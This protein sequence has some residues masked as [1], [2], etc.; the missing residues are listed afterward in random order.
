MKYLPCDQIARPSSHVSEALRFTKIKLGS[1]KGFLCALALSNVLNGAEQ[2]IGS[3]GCISLCIARQRTPTLGR[4]TVDCAHFSAGT[5]DSK[6]SLGSDS[7]K[8]VL[9]NSLIKRLAIFG[10]D[11]RAYGRQ[12]H[13]AFLQASA[14]NA[15]GF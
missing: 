9:I 2:F 12:V 5:H 10:V 8:K 1:L 7:S 3:S 15:V 11:H 6:F 14:K 4:Q 13:R